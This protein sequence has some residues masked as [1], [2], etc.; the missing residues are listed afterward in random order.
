MASQKISKRA[1][2]YMTTKDT[3]NTNLKLLYIFLFLRVLRAFVVKTGLFTG[4]SFLAAQFSYGPSVHWEPTTAL[5]RPFY[6][7]EGLTD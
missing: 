2:I 1:V 7:T 5:A 6:A 4:S 3:K